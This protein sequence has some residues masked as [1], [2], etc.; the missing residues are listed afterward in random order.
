M[1]RKSKQVAPDKVVLPKPTY[2]VGTYKGSRK[3]E[4]LAGG[5]FSRKDFDHFDFS[6]ADLSDTNFQGASLR[7]C[8]F[9]GANIEGADFRWTRATG[10][11]FSKAE[12]YAA[13]DLREV[14][15]RDE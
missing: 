8:N 11:D 10:T 9:E 15:Y 4:N 7:Y 13:A 1:G 12:N 2:Q 6:G 3:G 5:Q 14:A